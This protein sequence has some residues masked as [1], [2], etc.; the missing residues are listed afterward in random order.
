MKV[1][2]TTYD[3]RE[4]GGELMLFSE[5]ALFADAPAQATFGKTNYENAVGRRLTRLGSATVNHLCAGLD[6]VSVHLMV[7]DSR[8]RI[9]VPAGSK[10][11]STYDR[12]CSR[13]LSPRR[14]ELSLPQALERDLG[15]PVD[16]E[17]AG[18]KT[19]GAVPVN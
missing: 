10:T 2:V 6:G 9:V 14:G 13:I 4:G 12:V 5:D 7:G 3:R 18:N 17:L 8:I 11:A 16:V 15:E 1:R 19:A